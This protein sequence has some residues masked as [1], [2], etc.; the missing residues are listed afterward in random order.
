MCS[1]SILY[2]I[3]SIILEINHT[4]NIEVDIKSTYLGMPSD[5]KKTCI[6]ELYRLGDSMHHL[7]NVKATMTSYEIWKQ[8]DIFNPLINKVLDTIGI[9]FPIDDGKW[10]YQMSNCW[11]AIYEGGN[12][13]LP[14]KHIPAYLTFVYYFQTFDT[15]PLIF[16]DGE[17]LNLYPKNDSIVV[18][19]GNL[20]HSVPQHNH[21]LDRI[22]VAGNI[23]L[24]EK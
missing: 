6:D 12:H 10:K 15:T 14:H 13:T 24:V 11:G 2:I 7:S 3:N 20:T 23:A 17:G 22:C 18:F 5:Y 1:I 16:N 9:L 21:G 8:T 4:L 19:P